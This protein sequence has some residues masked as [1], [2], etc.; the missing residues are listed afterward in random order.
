MSAKASVSAQPI[1]GILLAAGKGSRFDPGANQLKLLAPLAG[2]QG[3]CC[4]A[5]SSASLRAACDA[6]I[7]VVAVDEHVQQ[8]ALREQ[9]SAAG[10]KLAFN[11]EAARGMGQSIAVGVR[12][13]RLHWPQ[14]MGCLI[15]LADMPWIEPDTMRRVAHAVRQG[16]LT[17]AP[18]MGRRWGH[19]VG[20]SAT[21]FSSLMQC[22]GDEGAR[23][24]LA[25]HPPHLIAVED[26][27]IFCDVDTLDDTFENQPPTAAERSAP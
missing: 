15:A 4:A 6:L 27:G 22:D 11:A 7:A 26:P 17:A 2:A 1:V 9:L 5:L 21:L 3:Q 8:P 25:Q 18:S 10:C 16:H 20:F 13:A 12:A 19:P 24:L 23:S 14:A